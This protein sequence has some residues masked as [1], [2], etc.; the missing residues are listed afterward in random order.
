MRSFSRLVTT[1]D[2]V[3]LWSLRTEVSQSPRSV[4]LKRRPP[5]SRPAASSEGLLPR[6]KAARK[7]SA[8][9]VSLSSY[10][11]VKQPGTRRSP[12]P[13]KP[14]KRS[15]LHASDLQSEALSLSSVWSF[16]GAPS[17]RQ[18]D[19]APYSRYI[20]FQGPSCQHLRPPK[21][22]DRTLAC[23]AKYIGF[24]RAPASP[25]AGANGPPTPHLG[26]IPRPFLPARREVSVRGNCTS[27]ITIGDGRHSP[28]KRRKVRLA[29]PATDRSGLGIVPG[30]SERSAAS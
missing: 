19:G 25:M 13:A 29:G 24:L 9:H 22:T 30:S 23:G 26:H 20:G 3:P 2:E 16:E 6:K 8:V 5:K 7:D 21:N 12:L 27:G 15:K 28:D 14:E 11:L 1:F 18:A 10:S 4:D 17:R